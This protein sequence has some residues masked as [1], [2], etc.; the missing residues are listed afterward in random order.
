M[1]RLEQEHNNLRK[2]LGWLIEGGDT[3]R[4]L[5][6]VVALWRYWRHSGQLIEGRRWC[7]SAIALPGDSPSPLRAK[8]YWAT[9]ALA[10]PQ[11]DYRRMS[12]LASRGLAFALESGDPMNL[13]NAHT[14]V[15]LVAM[16]EGRYRDALE[17]LHLALSFCRKLG[18]SW[19]LATSHLNLGLAL[20]HSGDLNNAGITLSDGLLIYV[21]LGDETFAA[22][23]RV[24][25][26][27]LALVNRSVAEAEALARA[28]LSA[29]A[30]TKER[31]GLAE[32]LVTM[33]AIRAASGESQ[34]AGELHGAAT[35]LRETIAAR[36][37]PFDDKIPNRFL[38]QA[39][40]ENSSSWEAARSNGH[41]MS[42]EAAI[43]KAL[44]RQAT[45]RHDADIPRSRTLG[46]P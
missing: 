3:E 31:Q 25:L 41:N 2:A 38:Y 20:L 29:F 22:R 46:I 44:G 35:A 34:V 19:Q 30:S 12:E 17:P 7:E 9:A 10:F 13:R 23:I 27:H 26:S 39:R 11:G 1:V 15:G 4:A 37:A 21:E 32:A 40:A 45:W 14:M 33:A 28:A 6:L 8:A 16:V 36:P 24:A 5:R 43:K 18:Q 42:F